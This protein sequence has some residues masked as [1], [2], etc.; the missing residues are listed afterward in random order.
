MKWFARL[1][2]VVGLCVAGWTS[3]GSAQLPAAAADFSFGV[4][5]ASMMIAAK[6]NSADAKLTTD[7]GQ[8]IDLN[9]TNISAYKDYKGLY[10]TLA[11]KIIANGPYGSV[12]ELLSLPSLSAAQKTRLEGYIA[13]EIFT[14]TEGD[15]VFRDGDDIINDG[16]YK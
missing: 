6:L 4:P 1:L 8:K 12:E 13:E 15:P 5:G 11:R 14:V 10:P 16:S 7:Y 3:L 2:A 9:N